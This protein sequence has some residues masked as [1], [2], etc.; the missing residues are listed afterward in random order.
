MK[1]IIFDFDG[2]IAD[3]FHTVLEISNR[4]ATEFGYP[5]TP[6]EAIEQLKDSSSR[7]ILQRSGVP[8]FQVPLLLQRL[9]A[10]MQLQVE[11]LKPIAGM[12]VVLETLHQQGHCLG[13]VTSNSRENV[14][15]FLQTQGL[16]ELF[17]FVVSGLT[18]F[19]KGRMIR[20]VLRQQHLNAAIV[21]YVGDE[22]RDIEAARQS[23][24]RSIAVSWG[25]NS[26]EV[27]AAQHPDFLIH[28]PAELVEVVAQLGN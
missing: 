19:G 26:S 22:T 12:K 15:A 28:T 7:E 1:V 9:R 16:S 4:L 20:R 13:I 24:I 14:I 10:E 2:T 18:L 17:D 3:S 11:Y 25:F 6:P 8:F 21:L 23:Q 27:L 5:V